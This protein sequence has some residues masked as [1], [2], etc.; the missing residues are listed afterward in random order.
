MKK[1]ITLISLI[2]GITFLFIA[3]YRYFNS[4]YM[5]RY[6][7][8][9]HLTEESDK[10]TFKATST[11]YDTNIYGTSVYIKANEKIAN[12]INELCESR[13]INLNEEVCLTFDCNKIKDIER[14]E[15]TTY[16]QIYKLIDIEQR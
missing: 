3:G 8:Y 10:C 14:K 15:N 12:Q 5:Y 11:T 9:C 4:T 13:S 2:C 1:K 16:F 7:F 6:I